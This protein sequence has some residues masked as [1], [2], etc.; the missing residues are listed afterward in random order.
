MSWIAGDPTASTPMERV[1]GTRPELLARYKAFYSA[2]WEADVLPRR[3]LE[4]CRQRIAAIHGCE[5]EQA[6]R[7]AKVRLSASEAKAVAAGNSEGFSEPE[8]IAL[9]I[10][11]RIPFDHHAVTDS[12]MAAARR[13]FGVPGAVALLTAL[14][15]F[16]SNCRWK[17]TFGLECQSADLTSPPLVNGNL[18]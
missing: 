7:D 8:R 17:L 9:A 16:D 3:V 1:F 5:Q 12:Q 14:C 15:L 6:L 18:V 2:I 4:L 13:S 10:A 11:E